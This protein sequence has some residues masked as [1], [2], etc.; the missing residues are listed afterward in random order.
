MTVVINEF[1]VVTERQSDLAKTDAAARQP[2]DSTSSEQ[3]TASTPRDMERVL[4]RQQQRLARVRA[5]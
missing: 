2:A 5:H 1:E 3:A 4:R